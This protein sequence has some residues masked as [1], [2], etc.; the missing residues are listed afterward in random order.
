MGRTS[1]SIYRQWGPAYKKWWKLATRS[2]F[3][4][5]TEMGRV[6]CRGQGRIMDIRLRETLHIALVTDVLGS[7]MSDLEQKKILIFSS[8]SL[9]ACCL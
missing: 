2:T 6:V 4:A 3:P 1:V 7:Q 9:L 5:T 8:H